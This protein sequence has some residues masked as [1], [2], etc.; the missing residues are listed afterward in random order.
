M[1]KNILK[2]FAQGLLII[3]P[4]TI[5]MLVL[6]K[7]VAYFYSLLSRFDL[8]FNSFIDP[9]LVLILLV[10][11]ILFTGWLASSIVF[12]PLFTFMG[13]TIE[14]IPVIKHIYS[15]IKDF[16]EAFVGNKKRFTKPVLILTNP[17]AGIEELGFITQEDLK[18]IGIKDKVAV[19]MP[20]SYAFS[21]KLI[22]VPRENIKPIDTKGGDAMK[23]I[24]TGGVADVH[25]ED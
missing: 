13:N 21:G 25:E 22:I 20:H 23:F 16:L 15:P 6:A 12:K 19:Y 3:V 17:Q 8:V 11:T 18:D 4:I 10:V 7:V 9:L 24:V 1:S 14:H 5:T 2:Y